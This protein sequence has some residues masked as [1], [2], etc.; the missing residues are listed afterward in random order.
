MPAAPTARVRKRPPPVASHG[1]DQALLNQVIDYY[2]ETLKQ[3]PE[4]LAYLKSR[5]LDHSDVIDQFKLGFAN[6]TLG[7]RLP[8]KGMTRPL[9]SYGGSSL[10]ATGIMVGMLLSFTRSRPQDTM[11]RILRKSL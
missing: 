10:I 7:L 8:A 6:R 3:S 4:A 1:D 11:G 9:V 5:G 2:H